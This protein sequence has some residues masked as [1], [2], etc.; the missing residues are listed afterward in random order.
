MALTYLI[1]ATFSRSLGPSPG[2]LGGGGGG[3]CGGLAFSFIISF[4]GYRLHHL[5]LILL[6]IFTT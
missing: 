4:P 1:T 6:Y 2:S 3:G 5:F